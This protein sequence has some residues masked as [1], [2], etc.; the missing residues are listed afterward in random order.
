MSDNTSAVDQ[1]ERTPP[2]RWY[3]FS[4]RSLLIFVSALVILA[5]WFGA[6]L[7]RASRQRA[8]IKAIVSDGGWA[9]YEYQHMSPGNATMFVY[10]RSP[11]P[12]WLLW[13]LGEDYF[14]I[15][16]KAGAMS[17]AGL[18][19]VQ[20]LTELKQL[21]IGSD[22][23]DRPGPMFSRPTPASVTDAGLNHIEN[24]TQLQSIVVVGS[25]IDDAG[26]E[27][28]ARLKQLEVLGL[29]QTRVTSDGI[30]RL[31]KAL[32]NCKIA[33]NPWQL[34]PLMKSPSRR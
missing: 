27:H 22:G 20:N 6:R 2:H 3:R 30:A 9:L 18:N 17:D 8:A 15:V 14:S 25:T 11:K 34:Y 12:A 23:S 33:D 1:L 32:P 7:Q 21:L 24:L 19:A 13:L 4:L 29:F 5:G 26:L 31:Q 10:E 28:F 16:D